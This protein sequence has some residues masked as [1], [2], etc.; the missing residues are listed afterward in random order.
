MNT[1]YNHTLDT[2]AATGN[3]RSIPAGATGEGIID[4]STN[5]YLGLASNIRLQQQFLAEAAS[6][7]RQLLT[8]SA[9]RLLA[10]AQ[11]EYAALE[12]PL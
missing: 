2:L 12:S 1:L 5:D 11:N 10:S 3:L 4:L 8:S 9:S 6:Q 7:S